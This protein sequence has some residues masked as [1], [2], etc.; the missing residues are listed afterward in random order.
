MTARAFALSALLALAPLAACSSQAAG[1]FDGARPT[2]EALVRAMTEALWT[3]NV[4]ALEAL[5]ITESE[6]RNTIWPALP[7]SRPEM[8]MPVDYLWNDASFKSRAGLAEVLREHGG[9]RWF[10]QQ[11]LFDGG[12]TD[13]GAF[14]IHPRTRLVLADE[15]GARH[16]A[17]LFGS[18]IESAGGWKIYSYVVD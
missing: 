18:M 14:R 3:R 1:A 10:V 8:G 4:R 9:R 7:A 5:A 15:R 11:V 6:F 13:Y 12:P 2:K 17:R 16:T